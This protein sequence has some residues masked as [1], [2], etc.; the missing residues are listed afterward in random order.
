VGAVAPIRPRQVTPIV[1][2][3]HIPSQFTDYDVVE[4]Y[5]TTRHNIHIDKRGAQ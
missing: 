4:R 1:V 3:T 5:D 2:I